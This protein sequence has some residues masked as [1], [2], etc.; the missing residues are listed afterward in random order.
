MIPPSTKPHKMIED[1]AELEAVLGRA[2]VLRL[3]MSYQGQPYVVP[4]SFGWEPGRVWLHTGPKG[5]KLSI[6]RANPRVCFEVE[7]LVEYLPAEGPCSWNC[8]YRTV[9]GFGRARVAESEAERRHGLGVI[10]AHYAGA[11]PFDPPEK[12]LAAATVICVEVE[13]LFGKANKL[14]D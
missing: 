5:W 14:D 1:Q 6:V 13:R 4:M 8:R 2:K 11:G 12:H 10:A 9:L 7:D 3:G